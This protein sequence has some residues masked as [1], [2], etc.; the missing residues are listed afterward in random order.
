MLTATAAKRPARSEES[1]KFLCFCRRAGFRE[2]SEVGFTS[3]SLP[4]PLTQ[5]EKN[6]AVKLFSGVELCQAT[7]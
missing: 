4:F 5:R 7:R 3:S 1:E 6:S 2:R